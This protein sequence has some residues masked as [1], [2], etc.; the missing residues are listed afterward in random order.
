MKKLLS[1]SLLLILLITAIGGCQGNTN[2]PVEPAS[3]SP[4]TTSAVKEPEYEPIDIRIGGLKGPTSIGMVQLMESAESGTAANN[5]IFTLA[6]AADE[7]TPKLIKGDLD[8][9]AIPANL[10]SVFYNNTDGDIQLMAINTLGVIYIVEKGNKIGSLEDLKGETIYATGKGSVPEY[11]LRYL[12]L[13]KGID[14]DKDINIQWKAEGAE[15]VALFKELDSGIALMPQPY[16]TIAQT[17]I[18]GLRIAVDLVQVWDELDN[19]SAMITGV[20]A[21]RKE[22]AEKNP[23]QIAAFLDEYKR[24]TEYVN[25]NVSEAAKLVDKFG[26]VKAAIAEKAIPYCNITFIEGADMKKA[27]QGYLSILFEQ[28]PKA[29]GGS[30]PGDDFYYER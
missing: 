1:I 27:L 13:Q 18:E 24:S 17:Q 8:M 29:V 16:V 7:I 22:F 21:V 6:G 9:A 26:I 14:P 30:L 2:T 3:T 5:Y 23:N 19:G 15:V 12:L 20:L 10:A 28:N 11:A 4:I 25:A